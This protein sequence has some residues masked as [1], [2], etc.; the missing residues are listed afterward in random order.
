MSSRKSK[1]RGKPKPEHKKAAKIPAPKGSY[2]IDDELLLYAVNFNVSNTKSL[3]Q[4][5]TKFKGEDATIKQI[6]DEFKIK[7]VGA[8]Y[9]KLAYD[10]YLTLVKIKKENKTVVVNGFTIT[11][12]M[13]YRL[14]SGEN[15]VLDELV[16][17]KNTLE[18]LLPISSG[19][20]ENRRRAGVRGTLQRIE[21]TLGIKTGV[22]TEEK[23]V[24][25]SK[26][27]MQDYITDIVL[28]LK[29]NKQ[30][31]NFEN[32]KSLA[33]KLGYKR[34]KLTA[35]MIMRKIKP[36]QIDE[37]AK[38]G[39][40]Y[41]I[42]Y[43]LGIAEAQKKKEEAARVAGAATLEEKIDLT[44]RHN[45][46]FEDVCAALKSI[47]ALTKEKIINVYF[48]AKYASSAGPY[49]QAQRTYKGNLEKAAEKGNP[50]KVPKIFYHPEHMQA[51]PSAL[52]LAGNVEGN[53]TIPAKD[54]DFIL[55]GTQ[56]VIRDAQAK[57]EAIDCLTRAAK[58][59]NVAPQVDYSQLLLA[60]NRTA[61]ALHSAKGT[62]PKTESESS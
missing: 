3:A 39:N 23:P 26:I 33:S 6:Q 37:L 57:Q 29:N 4:L 59:I 62:K 54:L 50:D 21:Q 11:P 44:R 46:R 5:L 49:Y 40:Q 32:V 8:V 13:R 27:N 20:S 24:E 10:A 34:P 28:Y 45:L 61:D 17:G 60:L 36:G 12:Y 22:L 30:E 43:L 1:S 38:T 14:N 15:R 48:R 31:I 16:N 56:L 35:N 51:Q 42:P 18:A 52:Y 25:L 55:Q 53:V 19:T 9:G 7:K 41:F 47:G 2:Q 58:I